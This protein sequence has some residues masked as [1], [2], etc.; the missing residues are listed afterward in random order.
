MISVILKTSLYALF[1]DHRLIMVRGVRGLRLAKFRQGRAS[2]VAGLIMEDNN[3]ILVGTSIM[4]KNWL[5]A[6]WKTSECKERPT[7]LLS[8]SF[9]SCNTS[10]AIRVQSFAVLKNII[11]NH[12]RNLI[13]ETG[14]TLH[15]DRVGYS[16]NCHLLEDKWLMS[17]DYQLSETRI[18][19]L[20][21]CWLKRDIMI[22]KTFYN[23]HCWVSIPWINELLAFWI[24][25]K[26]LGNR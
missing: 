26:V 13:F 3:I 20:P 8:S 1:N 24:C 11:L 12:P 6:L 10:S 2:I 7:Y 21:R 16:Q 15:K 14:V 22:S 17:I 9:R 4:K 19:I 5:N 25:A 23:Q 18:S